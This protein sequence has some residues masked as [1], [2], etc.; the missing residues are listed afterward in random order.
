M[1]YSAAKV[2]EISLS[3]D[4]N[5]EAAVEEEKFAPTMCNCRCYNAQSQIGHLYLLIRMFKKHSKGIQHSTQLLSTSYLRIIVVQEIAY[6]V[7]LHV[8]EIILSDILA[9]EF[10][11]L[12]SYMIPRAF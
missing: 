2:A 12:H 3:T 9:H 8:P 1:K 7:Q 5:S 6:I 10:Q 11:L 4:K